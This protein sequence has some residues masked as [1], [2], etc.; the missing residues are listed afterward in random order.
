LKFKEIFKN[1]FSID[2][3]KVEKLPW[4]DKLK[5]T[6]QN[7]MWHFENDCFTHMSMVCK[8]MHEI[9]S[10][11][12]VEKGSDEWVMCIVAALCHDIGKI[13]RGS[14]HNHAE[15]GERMTRNIF[16]DEDIVEREKVCYMVRNHMDILHMVKNESEYETTLTRLSNG[17]VP[18]KYMLYLYK[19]DSL[20]SIN[21][22]ETKQLI[23]RTYDEIRMKCEEMN[24]LEKP[25]EKVSKTQE[26]MG[27][28]CLPHHSN[29]AGG[30]FTVTMLCGF[31][32]SG[33]STYIENN[34]SDNVI[35]SIDE[36]RCE[37]GV[38]GSK[39]GDDKKRI[40]TKEMEKEVYRIYYDKL[41]KC[42]KN[43]VN[44]VLDNLYLRF[45]DRKEVLL[46]VM[47]YSPNIRIVYVEAPDFIDNI[48]KERRM[49]LVPQS[50][51]E[52]LNDMFDFPQLYEC[53]ELVIYKEFEEGDKT[54]T[55]K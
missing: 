52:K 35:I 1:D 15:L 29:D 10:D 54:Y 18:V 28:I 36:I 26:I 14:K 32:G 33:K 41:I 37:L 23:E 5:S 38:G 53:N 30:Q 3:E 55:F 46:R 25:Y 4:F 51:Y 8:A 22:V 21:A 27:L 20:G 6:P 49:G 11:N 19:S 9:L 12:N 43:K 13:I 40:G 2:W 17:L 44:C 7:T 50:A 48:C 16:F 24:C 39:I 47:K 42:C 34:I 45:E 31:P